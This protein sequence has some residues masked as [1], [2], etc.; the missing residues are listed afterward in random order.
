LDRTPSNG[1]RQP[2]ITAFTAASFERARFSDTPCGDPYAKKGALRF[3][4]IAMVV[5]GGLGVVGTVLLLMARHHR[6]SAL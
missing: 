1:H 4:L 5:G 6:Q 2:A 3:L